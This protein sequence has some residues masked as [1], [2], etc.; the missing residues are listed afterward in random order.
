MSKSS[1]VNYVTGG[2]RI[3]NQGLVDGFTILTLLMREIATAG[4]TNWLECSR[5]QGEDL[6]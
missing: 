6:P 3:S 1:G 5:T 2:E 4:C